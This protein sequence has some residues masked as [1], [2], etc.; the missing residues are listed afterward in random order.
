MTARTVL[1]MLPGAQFTRTDFAEHGFIAALD[2]PGRAV[3]AIIADLPQSRYL[4]GDVAPFLHQQVIAPI[5]AQGPARLFLL[6]VSL[7][8]MGALLTARAGLAGISGLLLLAPFIGTRGSVAAVTAAG[9]LDRWTPPPVG[10]DDVEI[11]LLTWLKSRPFGQ[12]GCPILRLGCG[13]GDRYAAASQILAAQLAPECATF[14]PGGHD[15]PTWE[16]LWH[17]M[18]DADPFGR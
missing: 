4:E 12:R 10:P 17:M 18:L 9:G 8:G 2:R 13:Q 16:R 6:G 3:E 15:W 14:I 1:V 7:G 5:L 11:G